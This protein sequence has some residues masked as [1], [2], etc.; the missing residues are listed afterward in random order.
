MGH[1]RKTYLNFRNSLLMLWKNLPR[2]RRRR[3]LRWRRVLDGVA[4]VRFLLTGQWEHVRAIRVAHRDAMRM[5]RTD[6]ADT[7]ASPAATPIATTDAGPQ[8]LGSILWHYY[9]LRHKR[10]SDL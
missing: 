2:E 4:A 9:I 6:Y 1:P 3:V 7:P 8:P 10:F 5:I